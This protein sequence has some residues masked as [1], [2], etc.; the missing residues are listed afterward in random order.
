[1]TLYKV[2]DEG[3]N[4]ADCGHDVEE[5]WTLELEDGCRCM[6]CY[7]P[8]VYHECRFGHDP[9]DGDP[10]CACGGFKRMSHE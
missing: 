2:W 6:S 5:H 9:E 4:C 3:W 1:M 10:R 8:A 7:K